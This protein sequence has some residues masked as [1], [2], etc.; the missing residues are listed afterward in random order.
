MFKKRREKQYQLALQELTQQQVL[1]Q[2]LLTLERMEELLESID[3]KIQRPDDHDPQ[4]AEMI[5]TWI[6]RNTQEMSE[7]S[8]HPDPSPKQHPQG[9]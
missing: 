7:I 5:A 8:L 6:N 9:G 4:T 3:A 1:Q 2:I